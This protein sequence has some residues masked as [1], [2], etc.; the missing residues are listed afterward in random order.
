[1]KLA[2]AR[3]L[4]HLA[5]EEVPDSVS[6]AYGV[7][8][9][10]F[11]ANYIIPKPFDPRVLFWV[12]PDVAQAAVD[13]GIARVDGFEKDQYREALRRR[14]SPTHAVL[15]TEYAKAPVLPDDDLRRG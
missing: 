3:A 14:V 15:S 10:K 13:E 2:A 11:G 7:D 5:R 6:E 4:A 9:I 1:M 12:A 8:A